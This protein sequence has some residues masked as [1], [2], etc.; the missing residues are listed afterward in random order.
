MA[1]IRASTYG[2]NAAVAAVPKDID[3]RH[4]WRQ[5]R[6]VGWTSRRPSGI[7]TDWRYVSPD[8]ESGL[9]GDA[10]DEETKDGDESVDMGDVSNDET[11]GEENIR[12]SQIDTSAQL[13]QAT[14]N[15]LF[16]SESEPEMELSQPAVSRAFDVSPSELEA[17]ESQPDMAVNLQLLSEVS[18]GES[19]GAREDAPEVNLVQQAAGRV[20]RPRIKNYVNY[21]AEN[22]NLDDYETFSSGESEDDGFDEG[23]DFD[24]R[25][26][27]VDE[28]EVG[29]GDAAAMDE[30]FVESR[31]IGSSKMSRS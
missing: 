17:A 1:R 9:L 2:K 10:E 30:A 7:Q 12:P 18:G 19:D 25:A 13:S 29:E 22:E 20:L 26:G 14:L 24:V 6:T 21:V 15:Q 31:Q 5:L 28:D 16:G 3:F 4:L 23:D 27:K 8:G 11:A